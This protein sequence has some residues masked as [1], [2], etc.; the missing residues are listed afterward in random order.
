[1]QLGANFQVDLVY[2]NFNSFMRINM[3]PNGKTRF[4]GYIG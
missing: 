1:M 4:A 3:Y 2:R